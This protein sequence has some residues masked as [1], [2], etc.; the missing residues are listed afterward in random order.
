MRTL[1]PLLPLLALLGA[2]PAAAGSLD[3]G[4]GSDCGGDAYSSAQVVDGPQ[5][6]PLVAVPQTLCADVAPQGPAANMQIDV[7]PFI[8]P[9]VG[10]DGGGVPYERRWSRR[11]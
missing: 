3:A 8:T 1:L 10:G 6:G 9:Q 11:Y 2:A 4:S 5:R 7:Y